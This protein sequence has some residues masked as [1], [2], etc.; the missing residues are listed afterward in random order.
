MHLNQ[1]K[2]AANAPHSEIRIVANNALIFNNHEDLAP[3]F[4]EI[5]SASDMSPAE[6][7]AQLEKLLKEHNDEPI[8]AS[9]LATYYRRTGN[10]DYA[11]QIVKNN[12][13]RFPLSLFARCDYAMLCL[14][15]NRPTQA[16]AA[17]DY[18]FELVNLYPK[19]TQ[20]HV[21]EVIDFNGFLVHYFC[22]I[23]D[24][25]RAVYTLDLLQSFAQDLSLLDS[26]KTVIIT[27]ILKENLSIESIKKLVRPNGEENKDENINKK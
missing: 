19:R 7:I 13:S 12:Y 2:P 8:L 23:K 17:I 16:V 10:H 6:G 9:H 14:E 24:F 26:L 21:L 18:T 3:K 11:D 4:F 20:F 27:A 1:Q 25:E 5:L 15:A 22:A